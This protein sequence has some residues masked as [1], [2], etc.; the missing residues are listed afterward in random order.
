MQA[1]QTLVLVGQLL[2]LGS[3]Q[4][5]IVMNRIATAANCRRDGVFV[6]VGGNITMISNSECQCA[7]QKNT[8]A[9]Y[10]YI[11]HLPNSPTPQALAQRSYHLRPPRP[12]AESPS[13][14]SCASTSAPPDLHNPKNT[15]SHAHDHPS[16]DGQRQ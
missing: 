10:Q 11:S 3:E 9:V 1:S 12:S 8:H 6:F 14:L 2:Q 13:S 7:S 16:R 4:V 5:W 15:Q